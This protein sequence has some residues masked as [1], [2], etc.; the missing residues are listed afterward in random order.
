MV[1]TIKVLPRREIVAVVSGSAYDWK[2]YTV[3]YVWTMHERNEKT[4]VDIDSY[5]EADLVTPLQTAEFA[6][7]YDAFDKEWHRSWSK[8]LASLGKSLDER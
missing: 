2:R 8:A 5:G 1:E 6:R 3:F 7:Y 4:V